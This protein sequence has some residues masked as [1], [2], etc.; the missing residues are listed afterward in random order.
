[1]RGLIARDFGPLRRW[2]ASM[3]GAFLSAIIM[4]AV[5]GLGLVMTASPAVATRIGVEHDH[6]IVRH[7]LYL[8]PSLVAMFLVSLL[9]PRL[10]WR[11]ASIGLVISLLGIVGTLLFG[12][13]IKGATRWI[14]ILGLNAQPSEFMKPCFVVVV[15]WLLARQ[16]TTESFP[17]VIAAGAIFGITAA[18]L[19]LQPDFGMTFVVTCTFIAMVFLAGCPLR[20]IMILMGL[21]LVGVVCAYLTL[22]HVNE[23]IDRFL[24]PQGGGDTYQVD[25]SLEAFANGGLLGTGPGEGL[26]KMQIPDAHADFIF[27]VAAEEMG[28]L[29]VVFLVALYA[30]IIIHGFMRLRAGNSVFGMLAGGGLLVMLGVQALIHMGSA[31]QLLPA[32]GMTLPF[33]SYGGSS[34]LAIGITFGVLLALTRGT[35]AR[36]HP[37]QWKNSALQEF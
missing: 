4:L 11:F 30:F 7:M 18:L 9:T 17:G 12:A 5:L 32:K 31:T 23:R 13:E 36:R 6:F 37:F 21:G 20:F 28:L 35:Q 34:L 33:I 19:L 26:I 10:V 1:M 2:W 16:K 3:D 24:N 8:L 29:F 25:R 27:S 14:N 15:G 22:D